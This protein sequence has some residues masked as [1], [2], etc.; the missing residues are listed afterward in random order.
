MLYVGTVTNPSSIKSF[1]WLSTCDTSA[2][3]G[4]TIKEQLK[5]TTDAI[6]TSGKNTV[7]D[8]K[9]SVENVKESAK[10]VATNIKDQVQKTKDSIQDLKNLKNI[11]K[12]P[13]TTT[14][15]G[16]TE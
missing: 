13:A 2:I 14:E 12:K 6:K 10:D 3:T 16:V 7:S 11:F 1:K 5:T 9:T 4:G 8:V 15:T